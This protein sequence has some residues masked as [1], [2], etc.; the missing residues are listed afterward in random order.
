MAEETGRS[1]LE[2]L[3][4]QGERIHKYVTDLCSLNADTGLLREKI[5]FLDTRPPHYYPRCFQANITFSSTERNLDLASNQNRL[6]AEKAREISTLS[7]FRSICTTCV[8]AFLR[9]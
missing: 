1:T 8:I 4:A 5:Q 9:H 3:G 2:R 6:A 7:K